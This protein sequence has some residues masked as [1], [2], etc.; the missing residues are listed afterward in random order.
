V[1]ILGFVMLRRG[2]TRAG[3]R[4]SRSPRSSCWTA[5]SGGACFV[6]GSRGVGSG[7]ALGAGAQRCNSRR[8]CVGRGRGGAVRGSASVQALRACGP[9]EALGVRVGLWQAERR[10]IT[11]MPSVRKTS[12]KPVTNLASRSRIRSPT[13]PNAPARLR[14]RA[15]WVTQGPS[16]AGGR[17]P[18]DR[19]AAANGGRAHCSFLRA[20]V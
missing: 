3:D 10:E 7:R 12:S 9:Q 14:L 16:R 18:R 4:P 19:V 11:S 5:V 20:G 8:R 6:A 17:V 15:C 13:S 2:G 1:P